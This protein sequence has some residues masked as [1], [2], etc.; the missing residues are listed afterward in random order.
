LRSAFP[1]AAA[2]LD[3]SLSDFVPVPLRRAAN[4]VGDDRLLGIARMVLVESRAFPDLAAIWHDEL[5]SRMLALIAGLIAKAQARGEARSGDPKLYAFSILGPM[6]M[7]VLFHEVFGSAR[8]TA[9]DLEKLADQ[10]AETILRGLL[11]SAS[12][13]GGP[14][15]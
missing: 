9:P 3:G 12:S 13:P 6:V 11:V 2:A 7:A 5:A 4:R 1:V 14:S 8:S 10:H 15:P